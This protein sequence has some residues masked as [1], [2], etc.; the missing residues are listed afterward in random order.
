MEPNLR[1]EPCATM[2]TKTGELKRRCKW[3]VPRSLA[4]SALLACVPPCQLAATLETEPSNEILVRIAANNI[5]HYAVSFSVLR[6][7]KLR[8]LRFDKE[9]TVS[10]Q[11]TYS[12][13]KGMTYDILESSGS[14][15]LAEIVEKVLASE[16][17]ASSPAKL[18]RHLIS[19]A[20]YEVSVRGTE[21]VA[22]RTCYV[23]DLV[24]KHKSKYL[25]KGTA[26]VDRSS[27][28]V[29]RLEGAPSASV[30]MWI[31]T[32]HIEMEFSPVDGLWLPVHTGAVSSS[33]LL[34]TSEL[35]IRYWDYVIMNPDTPTPSRAADSIQPSR[36]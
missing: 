22:K 24:P 18:A 3:H 34:G 20:N 2:A 13:S 36:P 32:P 33:L 25:V 12:P 4:I 11:V 15:K 31:G 10:V 8:N 30:S 16:A 23:I 7:Y 19:S 21:T 1:T 9:A 14:P 35:E 29:V 6:E 5:K 26:W 28:D 27:Y 17:D